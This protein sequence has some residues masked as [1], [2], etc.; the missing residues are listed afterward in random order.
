[1]ILSIIIPMYKVEQYIKKC[2]LSCISQDIPY[3]EYEIICI[4]DGSPDASAEIAGEI[5]KQDNNIRII[6]QE[7]QGLSVARNTGLKNAKGD[8]VWFVDSDDW[9]EEN[10]LGRIISKLS[11]NLDI[12]Q[13]QYRH[14]WL[15]PYSIKEFSPVL[16]K[17]VKSGVEV[18]IEG[19]LPDPAPFC[20]YRRKFLL[21]NDL[22]FVPGI[23]HEDSEF[24]PRVVYLAEKITS[25]DVVCYNYFQR[26]SGSIMSS[27]SVKRAN[28]LLFVNCNLYKFSLSIE[29]E[30]VYTF[31][32]KMG[33][34]I[35]T[36]LYGYRDL[37]SKDKAVVRMMLK[38]NTLSFK[39]MMHSKNLKYM[40]EGLFFRINIKLGL[41]LHK[42]LR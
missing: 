14:V 4:N 25:D 20:I 2:L 33:T 32:R 39:C 9:I 10:C 7:N 8:Y 26:Q 27:F 31:Y 16:I 42:T 24:K 18:T 19:G 17:G 11:N 15:D 36:L 28:N 1:M 41:M 12:L 38:D 3:S 30:C 5:A 13:L 21:D 23:Y 6:N 34:N 37:S 35:N 22:K 40:F 29:K